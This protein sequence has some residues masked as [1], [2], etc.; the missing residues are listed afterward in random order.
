MTDCHW[1]FANHEHNI[2]QCLENR[3]EEQRKTNISQS[4]VKEREMAGPSTN[5]LEG[6]LPITGRPLARPSPPAAAADLQHTAVRYR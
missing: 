5:F 2:E 1:R 3:G 4:G 6:N